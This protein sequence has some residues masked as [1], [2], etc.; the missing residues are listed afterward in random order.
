MGIVFI[1]GSPGSG[2]TTVRDELRK[3]GHQAYDGDLDQL[4]QWYDKE[5]QQPVA[6]PAREVWAT[7]EWRE[8]NEWKFVR[9]RFQAI[10]EQS[11]AAPVFICG[12]AG[13]DVEVW[14]LFSKVIFL[15]TT[16]ETLRHRLATRTGNVFGKEPFELEL[17]IGWT[18]G[19][20]EAYRGFG[21]LIVD[22]SRPLQ[23]VVE[24]II[25]LASK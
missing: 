14:D 17:I 1:T 8:R 23:E 18:K 15:N 4:A 13:N 6:L 3:R 9:E 20:E 11:G 25:D 7:E 19:A 12:S 24:E 22:A 2:K 10:A 5:T 16:E 21:A